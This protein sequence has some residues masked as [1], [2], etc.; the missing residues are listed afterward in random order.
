V[1]ETKCVAGTPECFFGHVWN[2]GGR[3][4]RQRQT[5]GPAGRGRETQSPLRSLADRWLA[6]WRAA[7]ARPARRG[8][9]RRGGVRLAEARR[10]ETRRGHAVAPHSFRRAAAGTEMNPLQPA[11][12]RFGENE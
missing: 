3:V 11:D 10:G 4:C 1:G 12:R 2:F 9:E 8:A 7:V 6:G 5:I